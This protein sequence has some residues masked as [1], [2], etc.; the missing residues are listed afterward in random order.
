MEIYVEESVYVGTDSNFEQLVTHDNQVLVEFYASWSSHCKALEPEYRKAALEL[1]EMGSTIKLARIDAT[2]E[3]QLAERFDIRGFPTLK[4]FDHGEEIEYGGGRTKNEIIDW[5]MKKTAGPVRYFETN[6]DIAKF[7]EKD[8]AVV[9]F[10]SDKESEAAKPLIEVA[11]H[12]DDVEFAICPATMAADFGAEAE[13]VTVFKKFDDGNV[14]A[15]TGLEAE[16]LFSLVDSH[17]FPLVT[18]FSDET[19]PKLFGGE[20]KRHVLLLISKKA[21]DFKTHLNTLRTVAAEFRGQMLFVYA[22][23]DVEDNVRI[24]E[25]FDVTKED[26]PAVRTVDLFGDMKLYKFDPPY[27]IA[28]YRQFLTAWQAGTIEPYFHLEKSPATQD[29]PVYTVVAESFEQAVKQ[30]GKNVFLWVYSSWCEHCKQLAPVWDSLAIALAENDDITIAKMN[31]LTNIVPELRVESFPTLKYVTKTGQIIDYN[32][33]RDFD[34]L[35]HFAQT[36]ELLSPLE[37]VPEQQIE[38]EEYMDEEMEDV[39]AAQ[40]DML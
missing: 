19:A 22:A 6:S 21:E 38:D 12:I 34:S 35:M 11:S 2:V 9:G 16:A 27:D 18:E 40:K 25:F 5:L 15:P 8:Y 20:I 4:F 3:T 37:Q 7:L 23:I 28:S 26:A 36:G 32:G 30:S 10:F 29:E 13:T 24:M 31:G 1:Q 39:S 17:R 33:A 14:T